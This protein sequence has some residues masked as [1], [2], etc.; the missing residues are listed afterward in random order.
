MLIYCFVFIYEYDYDFSGSG[1]GPYGPGLDWLSC[2]FVEVIDLCI[3][4]VIFG[5]YA[6]FIVFFFVFCRALGAACA[7][8]HEVGT[9]MSGLFF[10]DTDL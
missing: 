4:F 1:G 8:I 2:I 3:F 6:F 7:V 9:Q 5:S 10:G